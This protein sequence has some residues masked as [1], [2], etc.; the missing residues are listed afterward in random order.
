MD[1]LIAI[2]LLIICYFTGRSR[3]KK[4]YKSIRERE[5]K[6]YKQPHINFSKNVNISQ[7]VKNAQLV[8]ASVVIGCDYFK[9]FLASLR[10]IFGGNVSA[11]ESVL[12][13]GR[14]EAILRIRESA[15]RM[16]A[17]L[18]MNI[19]IETVMLSEQTMSQVCI[20]AYG[21]AVEY[22]KK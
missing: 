17:D 8:S 21:T 18:V 12:D 10:N 11:Y 3:E 16:R 6:L 2:A 15:Y 1:L 4:H 19:K 5:V 7:P 13:R 14:R 20:T 22:D 9:V